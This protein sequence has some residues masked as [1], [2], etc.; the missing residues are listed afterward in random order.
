ML[1]H[2]ERQITEEGDIIEIKI[3]EVEKSNNF[4]HGI[5][6]SLVY[7]HNKRV[8]G[9]DNERTK[10][11]HIHYFEE[12]KAYDY[13]NIKKLIEDFENDVKKIKKVLYGN[14]KN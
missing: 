2:Y 11:A 4:P 1:L 7:V 10:G 9:Y 3:W 13:I 5:K 6:Y 12:Y 14:K 8:L